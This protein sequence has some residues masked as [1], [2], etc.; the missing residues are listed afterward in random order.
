LINYFSSKQEDSNEQVEET[1]RRGSEF[2][3]NFNAEEN[4]SEDD[5]RKVLFYKGDKL[6]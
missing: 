5:R 2:F 6:H 3:P 1:F 4:K